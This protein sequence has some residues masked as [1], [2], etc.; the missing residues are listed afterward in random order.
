MKIHPTATVSQSAPLAAS[1]SVGPH[2]LIEGDVEVG[3]VCEIGAHAVVKRLVGGKSKIVRD[4]LPFFVTNGNPPRVRGLNSIG[5]RRAGFSAETRG[6]QKQAYQLLFRA[7]LPLLDA[8]TNIEHIDDENVRHLAEFI[9]LS[10]RGV[11]RARKSEDEP[12]A[13]SLLV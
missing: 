13:E 3:G 9:R 7:G 12:A 1:V 11:T 10:R 8:L 4:A 5:L 6:P 2:A